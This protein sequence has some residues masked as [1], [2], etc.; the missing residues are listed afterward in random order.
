M[1]DEEMVMK[2]LK[3]CN[4]EA[5]YGAKCNTECP[6]LDANRY[7]CVEDLIKDAFYLLKHKKQKTENQ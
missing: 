7:C 2:G 3:C 5:I 1:I 4:N 6:Y